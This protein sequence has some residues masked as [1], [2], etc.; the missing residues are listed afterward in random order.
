[1]RKWYQDFIGKRER[2]RK[3]KKGRSYERN[4]TEEHLSHTPV[5]SLQQNE[6]TY[7]AEHKTREIPWMNR[8]H[9]GYHHH[10]YAFLNQ[11]LSST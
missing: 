7:L 8:F 5:S 1:M 10:T 3:K 2:A 11:L 9:E 6:S 4:H